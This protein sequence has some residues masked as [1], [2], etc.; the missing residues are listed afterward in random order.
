MRR[1][2][3]ARRPRGLRGRRRVCGERRAGRGRLDGRRQFRS[4]TRRAQAAGCWQL[5]ASLARCSSAPRPEK[6]WDGSRTFPRVSPGPPD[7]DGPMMVRL[8]KCTNSR[9]F[10]DQVKLI[11]R[12]SPGRHAHTSLPGP[13]CPV[14]LRR[15]QPFAD[16]ADVAPPSVALPGI[17]ADPQLTSARSARALRSSCTALTGAPASTP[18][19]CCSPRYCALARHERWTPPPSLLSLTFTVDRAD[20][21]YISTP[22]SPSTRTHSGSKHTP[23]GSKAGC[24]VQVVWIYRSGSPDTDMEMNTLRLPPSAHLPN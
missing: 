9:H 15:V 7:N 5:G 18:D 8:C 3:G 12:S 22:H 6:R 2:S 13:P 10:P 4:G 19:C 20:S 23:S 17:P 21:S 14:L 11:F 24:A 1:R 16:P